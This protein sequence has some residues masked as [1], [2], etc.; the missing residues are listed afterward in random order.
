MIKKTRQMEEA[1][2]RKKLCRAVWL[3][4]TLCVYR[5]KRALFCVW[6][7]KFLLLNYTQSLLCNKMFSDIF[8]LQ[9]RKTY[10][11]DVKILCKHCGHNHNFYPFVWNDQWNQILI[12]Q[13]HRGKSLL[14]LRVTAF[15]PDWQAPLIFV[16]FTSK[17]HEL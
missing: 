1:I 15:L 10:S 6:K 11:H 16:W 13:T 7:E 2:F 5:T 12:D 8:T 4:A 17:S 14:E 9:R 3:L